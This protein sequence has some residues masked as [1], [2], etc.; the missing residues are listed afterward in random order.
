MKFKEKYQAYNAMKD[1]NN[2][3]CQG[4]KLFINYSNIK[5]EENQNNNNNNK[6]FNGRN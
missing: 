1:S 2:L 4:R 5:K 6:K 3:I